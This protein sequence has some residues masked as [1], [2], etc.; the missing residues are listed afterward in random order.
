M[1][2]DKT[3]T[4][5]QNKMVFRKCVIHGKMYGGAPDDL[6]VHPCPV[7]PALVPPPPGRGKEGGGKRDGPRLA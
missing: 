4:L 1:F 2:S 3:G 6:E 7:F 5:T